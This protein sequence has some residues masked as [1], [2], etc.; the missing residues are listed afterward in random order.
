MKRDPRLR[1]LSDDH[2]DALILARHAT[3]A[4]A[5]QGKQ[6]PR[7]AWADVVHR[8]ET[9][10]DPHFQLEELLLLPALTRLAEHEL[11]ARTEAE[12][13]QLRKL[14]R[15]DAG[16]VEARLAEFGA[17]LRDHVRFEERILFP[18]VEERVPAAVLEAV[19]AA[20]EAAR[21][22]PQ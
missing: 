19:F 5:G 21:N 12:H 9:G 14:V 16:P 13:A 1:W 7:D 3:R 15:E 20:C 2:H 6:S 18:A 11:V 8:F 17:A 4:G 22:P 10:V